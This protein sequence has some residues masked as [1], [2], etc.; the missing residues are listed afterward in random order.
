MHKVGVAMPI[1][2][3]HSDFTA[4]VL[5]VALYLGDTYVQ[6]LVKAAFI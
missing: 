6:H 5:S 3:L 1:N 2:Y 4:V